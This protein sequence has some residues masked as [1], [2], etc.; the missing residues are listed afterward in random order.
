MGRRSVLPDAYERLR[1]CV[2]DRFLVIRVED[3]SR[4]LPSPDTV[5]AFID[6]VKKVAASVQVVADVRLA[7]KITNDGLEVARSL[8][9]CAADF[10]C[11]ASDQKVLVERLRVPQESLRWVVVKAGRLPLDY[12]E[13]TLPPF[14]RDWEDE[15]RLGPLVAQYVGP[16]PPSVEEFAAIQ[17]RMFRSYGQFRSH[18]NARAYRGPAVARECLDWEIDLANLRMI[19]EWLYQ[20]AQNSILVEHTLQLAGDRVVCAT[21]RSHSAFPVELDGNVVI[22]RP[23][24]LARISGTLMTEEYLEFETLVGDANTSEHALQRFLETHPQVFKALGYSKVF[25]QVVLERIDG[26]C[27]KPDFILQ[28]LDS[29]WCD[30]VDIKLPTAS[31]VVGRRDRRTLAAAVHELAA[32]LREYR[33]YFENE[34]LANRVAERFGIKCYRPRLIG[35]IGRGTDEEQGRDLRR[36]MTAYDGLRLLSFDQLLA[37]AKSRLLI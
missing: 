2:E 32:Q 23:S 17:P 29:S 35:V 9:S 3:P 24:V 1:V 37:V 10:L 8:A 12:D 28:P 20:A 18:W 13:L 33:A 16:C 14:R 4:L 11:T 34:D 27:L 25:P 36:A 19:R 15:L 22:A 31:V 6:V 21:Y 5:E 26:S 7:S 30:I